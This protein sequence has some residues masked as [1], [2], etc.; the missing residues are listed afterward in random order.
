MSKKKTKK[1]SLTKDIISRRVPQIVGIYLA[2]SW[3]LIQFVIWLVN[4]FVLSPFLPQFTFVLLLSMLPTVVLFSYFHGKP[5]RDDWTKIE[6]IGVPVNVIF[7]IVILIFFFQGKELGAAE[8]KV[9]I[10]DEAGNRIERTII[11]NQFRKKIAVFAFENLSN[12]SSDNWL[13]YGMPYLLEFDLTQDMYIDVNTIYDF[14][15]KIKKADFSVKEKLPLTLKLKIARDSHLNFLLTGTFIRKNKNI[16]FKTKLYKVKN[17]KLIAENSFKGQNIFDVTDNIS[18]QLKK[19]FKIPSKHLE[20]VKDLPVSEILTSSYSVFRDYI[21]GINAQEI[22]NDYDKAIRSIEIAVKADPLFAM[23]YFK[24]GELYFRSGR[25]DDCKNVL[26]KLMK[27]IYKLPEREQFQVKAGY[28]LVEE[29]PAKILAIYKMW[30]DLYPEDIVAHSQLYSFYHSTS[31]EIDLAILEV[32]RI[33]EIDPAQYKYLLVLGDLYKET[34]KYDEAIR[35]YEYYAKIFPKTAKSFSKIGRVYERMGKFDEAKNYY[36]KAMLLDPGDIYIINDL[37]DIEKKSGNFIEAEK[38]YKEALG[39]SQTS[40]QRSAVYQHL[41]DLFELQGQISKTINCSELRLKERK[42]HVDPLNLIINEMFT[43]TK[44]IDIGKE[45]IAFSKIK[46]V[47]LEPPFDTVIS[48]PRLLLYLNLEDIENAEKE[49]KNGEKFINA[50]GNR[51]LQTFLVY[52]RGRIY[53]LKNNY[54]TAIEFYHKY[55][56]NKPAS[57]GAMVRIGICYKELEEYD[58]AVQSIENALKIMPVSP[59]SFYELALVYVESGDKVKAIE[60]LNKALDIWKNADLDFIPAQ[61]AG[62]KLAELTNV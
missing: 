36:E 44:Y 29:Q 24:L 9:T 46:S 38:Q 56:K 6:K 51:S 4:E 35:Y 48:F 58:K 57:T 55:L 37:G 32:E 33:L 52:A 61:K 39:E 19:D 53:E 18:N 23:A 8:K 47:K 62:K 3:G 50:F 60:Y 15:E 42:K 30:S 41:E 16:E 10:Y 28:Y 7:T 40:I 54:K 45:D 2:V 59:K 34:G 27:N 49:L 31:N 1:T 21:M 25:V 43:L 17:G 12:D 26:Q 20:N 14:A 11:K 13:R 22:Y 5:G